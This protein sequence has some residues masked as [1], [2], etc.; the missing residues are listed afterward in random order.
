MRRSL[1]L[2][3]GKKA[4]VQAF[5]VYLCCAGPDAGAQGAD[6]IAKLKD[7]PKILLARLEAPPVLVDPPEPGGA[8]LNP[9]SVGYMF[10]LIGALVGEAIAQAGFEAQKE[11][12]RRAGEE[13]ERT[14]KKHA[15]IDPA[16]HMQ[17]RMTTGLAEAGFQN[18]VEL[19]QP[20]S[21]RLV[22]AEIGREEKATLVLELS[23]DAIVLR[24]HDLRDVTYEAF[25]KL[26]SANDGSVV[27]RGQCY[28]ARPGAQGGVPTE[29][30]DKDAAAVLGARLKEVAEEC[31]RLFLRDLLAMPATAI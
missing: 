3:C 24:S 13:G 16:A 27:W 4:L 15:L 25:A 9:R 26:I 29:Q 19:L 21:R 30:S 12:M 11:D 6:A 20:M 2:A 22:T 23:S 17:S 5:A 31:A 8:A 14:A 18:I 1:I 7:V 28:P 10:G